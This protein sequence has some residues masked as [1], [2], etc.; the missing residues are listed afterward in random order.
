MDTKK[1]NA[2]HKR[3]EKFLLE[4]A[5]G[6]YGRCDKHN[7]ITKAKVKKF[8]KLA[9]MDDI[10]EAL[11]FDNKGMHSELIADIGTDNEGAIEL[12]D[13]IHNV[14]KPDD[15]EDIVIPDYYTVR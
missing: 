9:T 4:Y 6:T 1:I 2:D 10:K 3:A 12:E 11:W 8:L 5:K 13:L 15:D 14:I 7:K